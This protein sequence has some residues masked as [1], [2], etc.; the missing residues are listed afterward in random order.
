MWL[1]FVLLN[2]NLWALDAPA[3]AIEQAQAQA[4][5]KNRIAA[6][7][8]L[9]QAAQEPGTS[10]KSKARLQEA[11][12]TLSKVFFT[13][14]GQKLFEAA[15]SAMYENPDLALGQYREALKLEDDNVQILSNMARV[16]LAKQDC[17]GAL[18]TLERARALNNGLAEPAVLELR[19]LICQKN[20]EV[21]RE[22]LKTLPTLEG[23]QGAMVSYFTAQDLMQQKLWRKAYEA[24]LKVSEE[25]ALFPETYFYL[26]KVTTELNRESDAWAEKYS[27]LCK[28]LNGR[29]RRR[30]AYEPRLCA[31]AKEVADE[32]AKKNP[33]N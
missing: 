33:E 27:G 2:S 21:F 29:T 25:Q 24:L 7:K 13:D 9:T 8:I 32:M 19:T 14:K 18:T 4:L 31:N 23:E 5:R 15:Q 17:P 3:A 20:F 1:L 6:A 10:N 16:Q 12:N 30:F 11:L 28:G 22:K 26:I